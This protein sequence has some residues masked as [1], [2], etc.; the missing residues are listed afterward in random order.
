MN[1]GAPLRAW[2]ER[3]RTLSPPA[4]EQLTGFHRARFVGPGW[5]RHSAPVAIALGGLAG[6]QGKRFLGAGQATNVTATGERLPLHVALD[7]SW[8][9]GRPAW[10]LD[11]G[12][13]APLPWRRVRD[14]VRELAPGCW[15]GMTLVDLPG[16]RRIGWPFLLVRE[17]GDGA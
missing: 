6:W 4:P 16:L 14:E 8:L 2:R 5:L 10:R 7:A 9:D 1:D 11:Y 15:L 13:A 17:P 12:A 3:F